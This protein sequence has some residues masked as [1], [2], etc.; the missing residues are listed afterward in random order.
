[1][2]VEHGPWLKRTMVSQRSARKYFEELYGPITEKGVWGIP[3]NQELKD[4]YT[5]PDL[6]PDI[7]R[8]MMG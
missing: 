6:V 1:M 3:T 7:K 8:R 2:G 4:L 5:T